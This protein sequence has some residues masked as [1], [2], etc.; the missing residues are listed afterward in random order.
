MKNGVKLVDFFATFWPCFLFRKSI[1]EVF[2]VIFKKEN[3]EEE[4]QVDGVQLN[5]PNEMFFYAC[6]TVKCL[7]IIISIMVPQIN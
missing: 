5:Q 2:E 1:F 7:R 3:E 4:E 6:A